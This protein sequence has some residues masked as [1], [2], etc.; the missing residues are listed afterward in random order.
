MSGEALSRLSHQEMR[1]N[2]AGYFKSACAALGDQRA[3][4]WLINFLNEESMPG[5]AKPMTLADV[6]ANFMGYSS[7]KSQQTAGATLVSFWLRI[8]ANH[9]GFRD[10]S[11][12]RRQRS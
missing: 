1:A 12:D 7:V 3:A 6:G 4:T 11:G 10:F 2:H 8:L 9:Y 5:Q